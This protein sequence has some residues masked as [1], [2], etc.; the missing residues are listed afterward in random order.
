M[1]IPFASSVFCNSRGKRKLSVLFGII[2]VVHIFLFM[3][4]P[5][6]QY[7]IYSFMRLKYE[8]SIRV[9]GL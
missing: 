8:F 7:K 6:R 4:M 1:K 2:R 9:G 5:A 3:F